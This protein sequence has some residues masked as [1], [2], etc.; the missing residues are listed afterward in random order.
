M[1]ARSAEPPDKKTPRLRAKAGLTIADYG[2]VEA[3]FNRPHAS[4]FGD[5]A[6]STIHRK[7]AAPLQLMATNR[8]L[9]AAKLLNWFQ[10]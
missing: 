5:D 3:T 7:A 2:L 9:V 10:Y 8:A 4:V 1:P 6:Y